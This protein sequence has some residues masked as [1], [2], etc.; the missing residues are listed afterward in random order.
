MKLLI[1]GGAGFIGREVVR[2][3][4]SDNHKVV[5]LDNLSWGK[6]QVRNIKEFMSNPSFTFVQGDMLDEN[7]LKK[8]FG[9]TFDVCVHM[10]SYNVVQKSIDNPR[11]V[12]ENDVVGTFNVLERCRQTKTRLIFVSTCM[13]YDMVKEAFIDEKHPTKAVSPYGAAKIAAENFVLAYHQ[14]YGLDTMVLRPFNTYG[15]YG[16][17]P[18]GEAAVIPRFLRWH[19]LGEKLQIYGD[20][21]QTRDFLYVEDT[22]E[23]ILRAINTQ[24]LSG[25]IIN[26]GSGKEISI[27]DLALSITNDEGRI[28]FV[29]HHHPQSD[30]RRLLCDNS[31][32]KRL[33]G[34]EP[35]VS[36]REGMNKT[37]AWIKSQPEILKDLKQ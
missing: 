36:L 2:R 33:L 28:A 27:V 5:V 21:L 11:H 31:K 17:Y 16:V 19:L 20:G 26:G 18:T 23:F 22:A 14:T 7:L 29:T 6:E 30:V 15:P 9:E 10:A 32:A 34:F 35:K 37:L 3:L 24:G 13:V 12:M 4:L 8:T 1:I 25:Q